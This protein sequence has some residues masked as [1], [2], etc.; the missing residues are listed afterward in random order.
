MK[1]HVQCC[2][3]RNVHK[4]NTAVI[5]EPHNAAAFQGHMIWLQ[6]QGRISITGDAER[7][8]GR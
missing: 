4:Q 1:G 3:T 2:Y 6:L 8:L 7:N 5:D